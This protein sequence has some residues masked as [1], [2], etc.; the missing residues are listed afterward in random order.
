MPATL[1]SPRAGAPPRRS[2][3][4]RARAAAGR[5]SRRPRSR[6]NPASLEQR[7]PVVGIDPPELHLGLDAVG[8]HRER[9][10]AIGLVPVR[11]LVDPRLAL[12]PAVRASRRCRCG[13]GGTRRRRASRPARSRSCSARR[14]ASRSPSSRRCRSARNGTVTSGNVPR[15]GRSRMS[16]S[17]SSSVDAVRRRPLA[18]PAR[19]SPAS[20]STPTTRTPASAVGTATRPGADAD[21]EHRPAAMRAPGRRRRGCPR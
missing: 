12:D 10:P 8:P 11:P 9:E 3:S 17:T 21:L 15:S 2:R 16:A 7:P 18:A 14:T 4:R 20:V 19:A 6:S 1:S 13:R 5:T